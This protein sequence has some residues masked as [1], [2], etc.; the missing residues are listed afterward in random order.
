MVLKRNKKN[1]LHCHQ[2]HPL[3]WISDSSLDR[4]SVPGF[5]FRHRNILTSYCIYPL[6]FAVKVGLC[7]TIFAYRIYP[8]IRSGFC[9]LV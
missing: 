2:I 4:K 5:I 3:I 1:I 9:P 8:A 7:K 6:L